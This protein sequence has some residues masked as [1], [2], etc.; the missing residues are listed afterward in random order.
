MGILYAGKFEI[1][2]P[3][4]PF[5][6]ERR[7]AIADFHPASGLVGT[8]PRVLHI[9]QVFPFRDRALTKSLILDG[10][11]KFGFAVGFHPGTYEIAHGRKI[12]EC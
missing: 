5:F 10:L 7:G 12:V 9:A 6:L 11:K 8:P 3:V 4:R 1:L 2:F